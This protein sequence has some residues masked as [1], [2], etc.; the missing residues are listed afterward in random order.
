[1]ISKHLILCHPLLLLPSV[2]P[3]IRVFSN[4]STFCIRWPNYWNFSFNISPSKGFSGLISFRIDG[5]D[6]LEVQG[7][8]KSLLQHQNLQQFFKTSLWSN[9]HLYMT[10]CKS[11]ALTIWTFVSKVMSLFFN[12]LCRFVTVFLPRNKHHLILWLKSPSSVILEPKK[13]KYANVSTFSPIY[14]PQSDGTRC[15][16]LSFWMLSFKPAFLLSSFILIKRLLNSSSL[17]AIRVE[18]SAFLQLLTFSHSLDSNLWFIQSDISHY[19]LCLK[20]KWAV[21]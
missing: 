20:A 2:F 13:I 12:M 3:S 18:S 16:G 17:S 14:L 6:L 19:I 10:T 1:M 15:H 9:S 11:R 7:T 5:I 8:L 21:W 4:K